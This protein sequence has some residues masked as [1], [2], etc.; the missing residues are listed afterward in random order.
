MGSYLGQRE[1]YS[2]WRNAAFASTDMKYHQEKEGDRDQTGENNYNDQR[3]PRW[4]WN[5]HH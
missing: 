1:A 2:L 3:E 5:A 4:E